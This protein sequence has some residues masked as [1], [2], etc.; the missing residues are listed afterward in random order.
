L[1]ILTALAVPAGASGSST[2]EQG[3]RHAASRGKLVQLSGSRGCLV[4][5]SAP[6][7]SCGTARA[8]QGPGPFLGSRAVA[9]SPDGRNL[10]VASSRSDALAI[11]DRNAK[12]GT[13]TQR[14]GTAGCIAARGAGGCATAIGLDGP[15]S[16]AV[17]PDG[18][19]VYAT[20]RA[21]S[22]L[23]VFRR[24]PSNGAL[25]QLTG[26]GCISSLPLPGCAL[27]RALEG[28]DVVTLSPDGENVYVGAFF[29]NAVAMFDRDAST[30]ALAQPADTT[31]CITEAPT[32]DCATGLALA[33]P[34]GMAI[35]GDGEDVYV[36]TA[37]SNA[38]VVLARDQSTGALTEAADGSGC[39][40]DVPLAGCTTGLQLSGANAVAVSPDDDD[41]YVTSLLSNS[42]TSFTR[43]NQSVLTQ[44]PGT[45]GCLV[46]LVAVGCSHGESLSAPE[47]VAV[48]PDGASVY[49]AA[50]ETGAIAVLDRN[51]SSGAVVQKAGNA[52]CVA[53][54]SVA[55]CGRGRALR[56]VSSMD[57]S[58]DGRF[59]YAAAFGSDAVSVF[60]RKVPH[61]TNQKGTH[62]PI[63]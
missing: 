52:G 40:V 60:R 21:S 46:D 23:T 27:G 58:P 28:P 12:A 22:A 54:Q 37:V 32:A 14:K 62:G 43:S 59:L 10:Y 4:D 19:N 30:G 41:V 11:F 55:G 51:S 24:N 45:T 33:S 17:S 26:N 50:F 25:R 3:V 9:L 1:V 7:R 57:M 36:A 5:R 20:S 35:S 53:R 44:K 47:G 56:G 38:V 15:N 39:I 48:A 8:L 18:K 42:V 61:A 6:S 49:A 16:V 29:G 13:L 31:G 63:G 2:Q 34:E